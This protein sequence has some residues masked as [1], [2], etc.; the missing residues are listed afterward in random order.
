MDQ[1][2]EQAARPSVP[3]MDALLG[4]PFPVLDHGFVRLVDYMGDDSSIV[5]AARV[6]YGKGTKTARE[7]EALIKY[8][9]RHR[10]TTPFEMCEFKV[11]VKLP[12]FVARQWVRH[13]TASINEYSARYSILDSEFYLPQPEQLQPQSKQNRQGRAGAYTPVQAVDLLDILK[14]EGARSYQAYE[15]LLAGGTDGSAPGL[16][17]ELARIGLGVN[18]YTQW[19]WKTN[20]HNLL[21]FLSLRADPH[22]QWEIRVYAQVMLDMLKA[23]VPITH[24]AFL[25]YR[26]E[27]ANLSRSALNAVRAVIASGDPGSAQEYLQGR[28]LA[29]LITLLKLDQ[30][31]SGT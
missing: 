26:L 10:H 25:E 13:R 2:D 16:A 3:E 6:S 5:Q 8:L 31:S 29:E 30:L 20:L 18:F 17:R 24:A 19:Y 21:N 14:G 27:G 4:K 23:W 7:D 22:A 15:A 9:M 1:I 28:E 11:H 12:I